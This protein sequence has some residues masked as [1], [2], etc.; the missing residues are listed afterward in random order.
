MKAPQL[1][2]VSQEAEVAVYTSTD[3]CTGGRMFSGRLGAGAAGVE[4]YQ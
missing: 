4:E 2:G 3:G 1:A